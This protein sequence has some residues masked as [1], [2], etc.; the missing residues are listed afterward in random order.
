MRPSVSASP[1]AMTRATPGLM[2]KGSRA[3]LKRVRRVASLVDAVEVDLQV[4]V[5][6][7][8][9]KRPG[10]SPP[11]L[12]GVGP[13]RGCQSSQS[14]VPPRR[15][16]RTLVPSALVYPRTSCS[17]GDW[18][19]SRRGSASDSRSGLTDCRVDGVASPPLE[20][21]SKRPLTTSLATP[22]TPTARALAT[23]L[24]IGFFHASRSARPTRRSPFSRAFEPATT[25]T[26]L[27][28]A[29]AGW[30]LAE[31]SGAP[32][33]GFARGTSAQGCGGPS[34]KSDMVFEAGS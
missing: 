24:T 10:C 15:Y 14:F 4:D 19:G 18:R 7:V 11:A 22:M 9:I 23:V 13:L 8:C 34:P 31:P 17:S 33:T 26:P 3:S 27:P 28:P 32:Y 5:D 1:S 30:V 12:P 6:K 2:S 29:K 20:G 16:G 21:W 25:S